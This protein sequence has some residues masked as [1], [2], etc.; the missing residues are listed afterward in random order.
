MTVI[1]IFNQKGGVGKTTTALN[2]A[3]ALAQIRHT[4]CGIDLDPQAH[5]STMAGVTAASGDDTVLSLF[6]RERPLRELLCPSSSNIRI[7][8]SHLEL[9]KV[10]TMFGKGYD[11]VNRLNTSL[12][13]ERL[14]E[15]GAKVVIDCSPM[16]GVLSLNAIFASDCVLVPVSADHLSYKGALQIEKTLKA[17]EPVLK[18]RVRRRYVLTRFDAGR[19]VEREVRR[20]LEEHFRDE[21]CHTHITES[22]SLAECPAYN[23]TVF[24]HAPNSRGARDYVALLEELL[25]D[26]F[27]G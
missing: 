17:L 27:L 19:R 4:T 12:R 6:Q 9:S 11:V 13:A 26:R 18:R 1:A 7:I 24:E 8:P 21:V 3:A 15:D 23:K 16:I 5:L 20:M 14:S 25:A 22:A 2:L 10:D